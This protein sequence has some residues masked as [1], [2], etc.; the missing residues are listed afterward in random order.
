MDVLY[1][2][3]ALK[4]GINMKHKTTKMMLTGLALF[5]FT[6][7]NAQW[8]ITGN[9]GTSPS[10]NFLGTTDLQPLVFRTNNIEQMRMLTSGYLGIG[11]A[12]PQHR[13]SVAGGGIKSSD[14]SG[15]GGYLLL[16]NPTKSG[17]GI[18]QTWGIYNGTGA[19]NNGMHFWGYDNTGTPI[20]GWPT[21]TLGDNT[22]VGISISAPQY[23]LDVNGDINIPSANAL[24]IGG[25]KVL[26]SATQSIGV[27]KRSSIISSALGNVFVG[28]EAGNVNSSGT[29]NSFVGYQAGYSNTTGG[30]NSFFGNAAGYSNTS[31]TSNTYL[32]GGSGSLITNGSYNTYI[33]K[34]AARAS[35]S[36]DENVYV[37]YKGGENA[38]GS[39]NCYFGVE[40]SQGGTSGNDNVFIGYKSGRISSGSNAVI[41]GAYAGSG[42][43]SSGIENTFIGSYSG[44]ANTSGFYNLFL[45]STAG[46]GNTTG[47]SNIYLG[48]YSGRNLTTGSHNIT[49]GENAGSYYLSTSS[50]N[51]TIVGDNAG[52][53]PYANYNTFIG[54]NT[55]SE[56]S[57]NVMLGFGA[58]SLMGSSLSNVTAIG[59]NAYVTTPNTMVL[60][61]ISNTTVVIGRSAKTSLP[62]YRFE[63]YGD[64][65]TSGSSWYTSDEKLKNNIKTLNNGIELL[66]KLNPVT[67]EFK[68]DVYFKPEKGDTT[69]PIKME[70]AKGKQYGFLAQDLEKVI[71]EMVL[72]RPDGYKNVNYNQLFG[73]LVQGFKEQDV[74]VTES[75]QT[76]NSLNSEV[77]SLKES[78]AL[79]LGL[80]QDMQR[81]LDEIAATGNRTDEQAAREAGLADA[82][83]SYI[84]QT[85]PNPFT[86]QTVIK[87]NIAGFQKEAQIVITDDNA[88]K[89]FNFNIEEKGTGQVM[90]SGN[91]LKQGGYIAQ[92][93]VDGKVVDT[94]KLVLLTK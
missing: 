88:Q 7:S 36:G 40:S 19:Y 12:S 33:G 61:D 85:D 83:R 17:A 32:G 75:V 13:L 54:G 70:L 23:K 45:G 91:S 66:R 37:G 74:R 34:D 86:E 55:H 24:R 6:A 9:T 58:Y 76:I 20:G 41:I 71:P 14:G 10:T 52:V 67:Y 44:Y 69:A 63:V 92:L 59:A 78:N 82:G 56:G 65:Y 60:G 42:S 31:G 79:M 51:N 80:L 30:S 25:D 43:T 94:R 73:V 2:C 8:S 26:T 57:N 50:S 53:G 27:G 89:L 11:T 49:I 5:C 46:S 77:T 38:T 21:L 15:L 39:R 4:H 64:A 72:T 22:N 18:A 48:H 35:T 1:I 29:Y 16:E 68:N 87:Y 28:Q 90:L 62:S 3:I 93:I 81:R 84:M 47:A